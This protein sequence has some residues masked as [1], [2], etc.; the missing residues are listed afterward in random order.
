MSTKR[1]AFLQRTIFLV[2]ASLFFCSTTSTGDALRIDAQSFLAHVKYLASDD[3][4]GRGNGSP[5]LEKA[6]DYIARHFRIAH[7]EPGGDKATYFQPFELA[8]RISVGDRNSLTI[9]AAGHP[10]AGHVGVDYYPISLTSDPASSPERLPLVFAGYGITAPALGYDDFAGIDVTGKAVMIFT[11][12]PQ[13][14]DPASAFDGK[15]NTIHATTMQK[16]MVARRQGARLLLIVED[17]GHDD[18]SATFERWLKDPQAEEYGIEVARVSRR[19]ATQALASSMDLEGVAKAIDG[20]LKPRSQAVADASVTYVEHLTKVRRMVRNVIGVLRG[21]DPTRRQEAIVVGAH[22]DHLGLGGRSSL[23]DN[24]Y[25]LIHNGADDNASG[26]SAMLEIARIAAASRESFP[27]TIVFVAFAGEEL[28]LLGSTY[29]VNHPTVPLDHTTAMVNLDMIGRPAGRI[30]LSGLDSAPSLQT[31]VDSA[32][33]GLSLE[34]KTFREGASV[35]SSDDTSFVLRRI[36]SIGFFS[37]F[38]ADYHKPTDD[39]QKIDAQGGV[40]VAQLALALARQLANRS[41]RPE[42]VEQAPT[43]HESVAASGA[44]TG[45]YGPY[46]GSVPDFGSDQEG[47]KFADVRTGSPAANAGFRRGDV[48]VEFG[49]TKV[50]TLYD[51]TF[52]LRQKRPGDK[53]E[54]TVLRDGQEIRATV[55]LGNRP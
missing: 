46:F 41:T 52:A 3:L 10:V 28:G 27:R 4:Q 23:V 11:H 39:W 15:A 29:Y 38:H 51:F 44:G 43:G 5:G 49:G 18:E 45:G 9:T 42:F 24:P 31:D 14:N 30:L 16:A 2:S 34:I 48:L 17:P 36:P 50:K 1:P 19:L 37:G 32:K 54:V 7:L 22:Y 55:E 35:G 25:G 53:V 47:V 21:S 40:V 8:A 33:N 26:T 12:E 13:E 6:A 20:D